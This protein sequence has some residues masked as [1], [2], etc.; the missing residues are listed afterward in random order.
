[1]NKVQADER[2]YPFQRLRHV[3]LLRV[4]VNFPKQQFNFQKYQPQDK[5]VAIRPNPIYSVLFS[6]TRNRT[7]FLFARSSYRPCSTKRTL[8]KIIRDQKGYNF[9]TF[10]KHKSQRCWI[11]AGGTQFFFFQKYHG[12]VQLRKKFFSPT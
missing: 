3:K 5:I 8:K 11:K 7:A 2:V 6:S 10:L 1:M 9:K 12:I 4:S